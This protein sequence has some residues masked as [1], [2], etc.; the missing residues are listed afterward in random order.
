MPRA[1]L[2]P[3]LLGLIVLSVHAQDAPQTI[4]ICDES[5]CSERAR[6]TVT[7]SPQVNRDPAMERRYAELVALAEADPR[8]AYDLGLRYFRGDGVSQDSHRALEWMRNAASRG[9]LPAQT[10]VGR[11]YLSGLEEM[12]SDPAE[13]EKWLQAAAGRG[14][15]EAAKLLVD[16]QKAKQSEVAYQRWKD[17]QREQSRNFWL[18]MYEYQWQWRDDDRWHERH[19]SRSRRY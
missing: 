18:G 2:F 3:F 19:V 7:F 8:A 6:D 16:A 11:L 5:G 15:K 1:G 13:A 10:A 14:D 17:I 9:Y 12:G 4:R